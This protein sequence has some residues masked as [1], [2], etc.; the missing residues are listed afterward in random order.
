MKKYVEVGVFLCALLTLHPCLFTQ[1]ETDTPTH[2]IRGS[3]D[4]RSDVD[5]MEI[6][7]I[8]YGSMKQNFETSIVQPVAWFLYRLSSSGSSTVSPLSD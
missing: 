1:G 6:R 2:W 8:V 3:V 5:P 7:N 4:R